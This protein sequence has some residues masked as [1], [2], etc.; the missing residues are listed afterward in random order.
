MSYPNLSEMFQR[1]NAEYFDGVLPDIPVQYNSRKTK[2]LFGMYSYRLR[3][4]PDPNGVPI[5]KT[6]PLYGFTL[7][8]KP[9][10]RE[11][12][13]QRIQVYRKAV[14]H[15]VVAQT[16][17]HEMTHYYLHFRGLPNGHTP[18]FKAYMSHFLGKQVK[19]RFVQRENQVKSEEK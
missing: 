2:N 5:Q 4:V 16:L 14:E 9:F 1:F 7:T 19:N 11:V 17:F 18:L 10:K 3:S 8:L 13:G 12:T 6:D 15:G